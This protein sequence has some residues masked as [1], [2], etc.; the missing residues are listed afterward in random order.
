MCVKCTLNI[1]FENFILELLYL[2]NFYPVLSPPIPPHDYIF[3]L[4]WVWAYECHR[5]PVE[6]RVQPWESVLFLGFVSQYR[7]WELHSGCQMF[8]AWTFPAE[9]YLAN[10]MEPFRDIY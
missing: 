10:L 6:V 8:M 3:Y 2:Y 4:L 9:L 7:F 5:N 1:V